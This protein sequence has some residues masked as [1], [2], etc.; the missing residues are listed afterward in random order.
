MY[1]LLY[2]KVIE[3]KKKISFQ[4]NYKIHN[5]AMITPESEFF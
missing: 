3:D 4:E 5:L 1:Y 2:S